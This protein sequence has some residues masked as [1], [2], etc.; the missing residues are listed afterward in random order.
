MIFS[1]CFCCVST[2]P[3][4][5][6]NNFLTHINVIIYFFIAVR[7]LFTELAMNMHTQTH[8]PSGKT[9]IRNS[10]GLKDPEYLT[11]REKKLLDKILCY[12]TYFATR[13][14]VEEIISVLKCEGKP[15]GASPSL[16]QLVS[17]CRLSFQ[18][19]GLA[20]TETV[21]GAEGSDEI[22]LLLF[23]QHQ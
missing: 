20:E 6:G 18:W 3:T 14:T 22:S 23:F 19:L 8:I 16:H 17:P 1:S 9:N 10:K 4:L 15:W 12:K 7:S 13:K 21:L 11:R 5:S 2:Q